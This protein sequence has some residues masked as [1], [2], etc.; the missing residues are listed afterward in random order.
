VWIVAVVIIRRLYR[1]LVEVPIHG[2][3]NWETAG[4]PSLSPA[5][6]MQTG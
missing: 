1:T 5:T 2:G 4:G 3:D 6:G